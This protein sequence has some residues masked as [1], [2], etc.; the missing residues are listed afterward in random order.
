MGEF[1]ELVFEEDGG[2]DC[3]YGA[4][5]V[6][7]DG[8]RQVIFEIDQQYHGQEPCDYSYRS[9]EAEKIAKAIVDWHNS[10]LSKGKK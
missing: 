6:Y 7:R 10:E 9:P 2:Y 4:W 5:V 8:T 1:W 3:M